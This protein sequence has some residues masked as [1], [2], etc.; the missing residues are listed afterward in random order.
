[1]EG[2]YRTTSQKR[3]TYGPS[4]LTIAVWACLVMAIVGVLYVFMNPAVDAGRLA[5]M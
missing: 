4:P 3:I 5:G 1:M 2:I